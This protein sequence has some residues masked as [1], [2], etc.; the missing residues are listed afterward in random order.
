VCLYLEIDVNTTKSNIDL[1]VLKS[2]FVV[3]SLN[4]KYLMELFIKVKNI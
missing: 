1:I 4:L 3:Y 2:V